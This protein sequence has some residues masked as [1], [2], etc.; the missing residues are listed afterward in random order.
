MKVE[1]AMTT[2][3]ANKLGSKIYACPYLEKASKIVK[4]LFWR[5]WKTS[6]RTVFQERMSGYVLFL[7]GVW[8]RLLNKFY[9]SLCIRLWNFL[10]LSSNI[11]IWE[12][13]RFQRFMTGFGLMTVLY[14]FFYFSVGIFNV[15]NEIIWVSWMVRVSIKSSLKCCKNSKEI[16]RGFFDVYT[17]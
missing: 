11:S 7:E 3:H 6:I 13:L 1:R 16:D 12:L 5:I 15:S 10:S 4:N 17:L 2:V 9:K 14:D 8:I